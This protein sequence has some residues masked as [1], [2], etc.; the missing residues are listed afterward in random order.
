M[1][2]LCLGKKR[3]KKIGW[4]K[5]YPHSLALSCGRIIREKSR[6]L[7]RHDMWW[8]LMLNITK[9]N[10][11]S[12]CYFEMVFMHLVSFIHCCSFS[13]VVVGIWFYFLH[14]TQLI[15]CDFLCGLLKIVYSHVHAHHIY[16]SLCMHSEMTC[17]ILTFIQTVDAHSN[18]FRTLL[19][20]ECARFFAS[21]DC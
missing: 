8:W 13:A 4:K 16:V 17:T 1:R 15:E 10:M 9:W 3:M 18:H 21:H 19:L 7:R 20:N 14:F 2:S 12:K 11:C 5:S 6:A